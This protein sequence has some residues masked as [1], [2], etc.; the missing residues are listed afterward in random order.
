MKASIKN[1][2]DAIILSIDGKVDYES[3]DQVC[4]TI[5]KTIENNKKNNQ[6]KQ[7]IVNFEKLEFVGSCG[8][9]QFVQNLKSIHTD[10]SVVPKYCGV[11]SEFQKI[12]NAFDEEHEF[13]FFEDETLS[14]QTSK[15]R[16][17][18]RSK[19]DH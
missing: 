14:P 6:P 10:T 9:T 15:V 7:I 4:D 13:E 5:I 16:S 12:M 1:N 8:I 3:Q 19:L 11:R 17:G 18:K 2:I